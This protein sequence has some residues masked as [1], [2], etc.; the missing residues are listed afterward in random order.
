MAFGE[1]SM[2]RHSHRF[3]EEYEG[4]VGFGLDRVTNESTVWYY[5]QKF[6]DDRLM[7]TILKK[8]SDQDLE[9]LF[10]TICTLLKKYLTEEEYHRLFLKD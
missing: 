2:D 5:I 3:V 7:E 4:L 9:L 8:M 10:E 1:R 6:S